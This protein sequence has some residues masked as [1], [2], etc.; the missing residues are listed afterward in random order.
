MNITL[1]ITELQGLVPA[2]LAD[3][4]DREKW[5][6]MRDARAKLW[7]AL[8][9]AERQQGSTYKML[10]Y[11]TND[12]KDRVVHL[13]HRFPWAWDAL[14]SIYY[15]GVVRTQEQ[16]YALVRLVTG[17]KLTLAQAQEVVEM[18]YQ[19]TGEYERHQHANPEATFAESLAYARGVHIHEWTTERFG[20]SNPILGTYNYTYV[21]TCECG[22]ERTERRVQNWSGD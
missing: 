21:H 18:G 6:A 5:D 10:T 16:H 13:T 3:K 14:L 2:D 17:G 7:D 11:Y 12:T 9:E 8:L 22:A 1:D 19:R 4:D 15:G 20:D